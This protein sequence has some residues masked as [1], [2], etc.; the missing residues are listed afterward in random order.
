MNLAAPSADADDVRMPQFVVHAHDRK[1]SRRTVRLGCEV[2]RTRDYRL[3]GKKMLDLSLSGLQVLAEDELQAGENVEVFFRVPYS[4]VWVL[5]EGSVARIIG[6][7]RPG[8]DGPAFGIELA[9]LHPDALAALKN[10]QNRF[11][12]TMAWRPRRV[13]YAATV[14]AITLS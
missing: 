8:D 14:Q 7:K 4:S 5:A 3:V 12:P 10:A 9:P 6:G 13:D 11:P 1:T 2:V